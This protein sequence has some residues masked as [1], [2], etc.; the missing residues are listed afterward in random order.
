MSVSQVAFA[1]YGRRAGHIE[2][3][4]GRLSLAY[5]AAYLEDDTATPLSLSMPLSPERYPHRPV[6]AYLRGLLPDR[7]DVRER[8]ASHFAVRD[9][10]TLG[11]IAAIG[12][13]CAGGVIFAPDDKLE[14]MLA[15]HGDIEPVTEAEIAVRLRALRADD[16]AWHEHD[17]HW[18]LAGGQG[19]F[20]MA[21]IEGGWGLPAG[22]APSTHIVK[23][24]VSRIPAQ[25]LAEH[26]SM[27]ALALA[28]LSAADTRYVE[29]E[30]Q[31]AIV[32]KRFDRRTAPD[33]RVV[34]LHQEDMVQTFALDPSRK[35]EA[36]RGPGIADMTARLRQAAGEVSVDRFIDATIASYLLGAPDGHAKNH[37]LLLIG[38]TAELAPLYDVATGLVPV[39]GRLRF[40]SAA[41]SIGGEKRFGEVEGKHWDRFARIVDRDPPDIRNRVRRLA[42]A[43][44]GAFAEAIDELP[45]SPDRQLMADQVLPLIRALD[46]QTVRGLS[47]SRRVGG[48]VVTLFLSG[49]ENRGEDSNPPPP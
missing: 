38:R 17:E 34:R 30:D 48:R 35:Y 33:G 24:G 16:A 31:P 13:D 11:L 39:A 29:F 2:R 3:A 14:A 47:S 28:G 45:P 9:R 43:I 6:E 4:A 26:L 41:T 37:A 5:D 21:Q 40:T 15:R 27:R 18:S 46:E 10:D 25:A 1:L 12:L 20:T 7:A 23:P 32:V 22:S 44:P 19:K 49:L 42:A 8:W 36:D